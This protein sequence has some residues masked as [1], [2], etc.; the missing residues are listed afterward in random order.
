M[1]N[2]EKSELVIARIL[3][4]LMERGIQEGLVEFSELN[5]DEELADF[6]FPCFVWLEREGLVT[7]HKVDRYSSNKTRAGGHIVN[8]S[9]TS[10]GYAVLGGIIVIG[11]QSY[12]ASEAVAQV[13]EKGRSYSGI[14]DFFGG[15]LGGLTKSLGS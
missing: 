12:S 3:H 6:F 9:L 11:D 4:F 10:H 15:L 1:N 13:S 2:T 14:G 8:P 7:S 5:L